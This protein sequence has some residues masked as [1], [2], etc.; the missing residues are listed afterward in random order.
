MLLP[1]LLPL[2]GWSDR[3]PETPWSI[4]GLAVFA[5]L[6]SGLASVVYSG[7]DPATR[8]I[9]WACRIAV[10][11]LFAREYAY[12]YRNLRVFRRLPRFNW[13]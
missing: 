8:V 3:Q 2:A 9:R 11:G 10:I 13:W 12:F 5:L 1:V 4:A 6:A 7:E